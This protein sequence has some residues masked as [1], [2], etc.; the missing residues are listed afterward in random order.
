MINYYIRHAPTYSYYGVECLRPNE[1]RGYSIFLS[2]LSGENFV[3]YS[4]V[5]HTS[6]ECDLEINKVKEWCKVRKF[7]I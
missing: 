4:L 6:F 7:V 5:S 3:D 2:P 1:N